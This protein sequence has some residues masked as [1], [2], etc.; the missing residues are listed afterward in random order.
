MSFKARAGCFWEIGMFDLTY[1]GLPA[2][3]AGIIFMML[4]S[5][6]LLPGPKKKD[7]AKEGKR[8]FGSE[9]IVS[10]GSPLI[11]KTLEEMG[12]VKPVGFRLLE[13]RRNN[14]DSIEIK[15]ETRLTEGDVLVFSSEVELIADLWG[16]EGL[17][18]LHGSSVHE[19]TAERHSHRL[20]EVVV[21]RRASAVGRQIKEPTPIFSA[22][23]R[24]VSGN[25]FLI[26][27]RLFVRTARFSLNTRTASSSLASPC[28]AKGVF[29][30]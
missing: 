4:T 25:C 26:S 15:P 2:T 24:V 7:E 27:A 12:Y 13:L 17:L 28:R 18:P 10:P 29:C 20:V 19:V 6:F 9:F 5:R 11:D 21:S 30:R 8:L 1:I 22:A 16:T 3:I 23:V 14:R